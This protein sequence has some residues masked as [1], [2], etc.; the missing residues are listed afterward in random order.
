[1]GVDVGGR[2]RLAYRRAD[3]RGKGQ[4]GTLWKQFMDNFSRALFSGFIGSIAVDDD[5]ATGR[6][7]TVEDLWLKTGSIQRL[8]G[9]Y[10]DE[11]VRRDGRWLFKNRS[12]TVVQEVPITVPDHG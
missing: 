8:Q 5:T 4:D 1:M 11:I 3:H 9:R 7:H 10:A 2:L 6:Y 12:Y